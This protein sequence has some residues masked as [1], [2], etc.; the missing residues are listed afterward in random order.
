MVG[1]F[2]E[3]VL[4][5]DMDAFF[6]EVERRR[7]PSLRG[8]PV[9]VGGIGPRGVVASASYEA[10]RRGVRS[11]MPTAHARRQAP[12]ARFI[13]PDHS[14]YRDASRE[15]FEVIETFTPLVEQLSV[16]EAFLDISGLRLHYDSVEDV[17]SSLRSAIKEATGLPASVG[18]A[19]SKLIAKLASEEAKPDGMFIVR[20][21]TE[22]AFLHPKD[23]GELWHVGQATR[24][25]LE[26]LGIVTIGDLASFPLDTL[27]RRLGPTMGAMLSD[28][29]AA[30][31]PRPVVSGGGAKSISVEQTYETDID[32]PA[33]L[34]RELLKHADLLSRRLRS[35]GMAGTTVTLKV[36]LADFDTLTRSETG[37][38]TSSAHDL[39][40]A[41]KRLLERSGVGD[42]PIRL[43]G[44]GMTGLEP[45]DAPKQ[46]DIG[47]PGW[48]EVDDAVAKVRDRFGDGSVG[49]ARL[50]DPPKCQ[51]S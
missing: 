10:R 21:G 37:S 34:E 45:I 38:A 13:P 26:E 8:V 19:T 31:D 22:T 20:A 1:S 40:E 18:I 29:A 36:R 49:P 7:D 50:V 51:D 14:A 16:D 2:A 43:L 35:A 5:F 12:S 11:A 42:R 9:I 33:V 25:R 23:V 4:H 48:S 3:C 27:R 44:V 46:L 17:G 47:G 15:V 30:H 6:V 28:L 24:A 41:G 32:D 39:F